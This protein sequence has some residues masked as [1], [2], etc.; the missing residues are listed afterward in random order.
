MG[1]LHLSK[2]WNYIGISKSSD[3]ID[4]RLNDPETRQRFELCADDKGIQLVS[5]GPVWPPGSSGEVIL[6]SHLSLMC[7]SIRTDLGSHG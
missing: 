5:F 2:K 1:D 7:W 6:I 3:N 4:F